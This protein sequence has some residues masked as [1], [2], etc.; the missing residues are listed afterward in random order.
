MRPSSRSMKCRTAARCFLIGDFARGPFT[1]FPP[2]SPSPLLCLTELPS[3]SPT[4]LPSYGLAAIPAAQP[5]AA[6][7]PPVRKPCV[8]KLA[9]HHS[10]AEARTKA[11]QT[12]ASLQGRGR[13]ADEPRALRNGHALAS[14]RGRCAGRSDS[15]GKSAAIAPLL[16]AAHRLR[17]LTPFSNRPTA[18]LGADFSPLR[19]ARPP[20]SRRVQDL[21]SIVRIAR[22]P[23]PPSGPFESFISPACTI[24]GASSRRRRHARRASGHPHAAGATLAAL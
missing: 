9:S 23:R 13:Y 22:P 20:P 12:T 6:E 2:I 16:P 19:P 4:T 7:A 10:L 18:A 3:S 1:E 14:E 17:S 15:A 5:P 21:R 24:V 11:C 8:L